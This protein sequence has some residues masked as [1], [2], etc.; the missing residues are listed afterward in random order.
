MAILMKDDGDFEAAEAVAAV[1]SVCLVRAI[2]A[3]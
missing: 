1:H 2:C 3:L